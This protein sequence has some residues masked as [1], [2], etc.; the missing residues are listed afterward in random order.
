MASNDDSSSP[1]RPTLTLIRC[2]DDD[3]AE[4]LPQPSRPTDAGKTLKPGRTPKSDRGPRAE[5]NCWRIRLQRYPTSTNPRMVN[6]IAAIALDGH[7]CTGWMSGP[8]FE[9]LREFR[10]R[11]D[12]SDGAVY[13]KATDTPAGHRGDLAELRRVWIALFDAHF[14]WP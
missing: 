1:R 7:L 6:F 13:G 4:G 12:P 8:S 14:S 3:S 5:D 9:R 10:L 11:R 2:S